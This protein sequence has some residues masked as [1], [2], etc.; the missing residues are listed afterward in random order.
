MKRTL[1]L[2]AATLLVL[3][4]A[5]VASA[6]DG[7]GVYSDVTGAINC[8]A[9]PAPYSVVTLYLVAK[10]ISSASGLSGWECALTLDPPAPL[11]LSYT[12]LNGGLNV[13]APPLFQVGLG[14]VVPYAD[15]IP[16]AN[17]GFLAPLSG[18][19][20]VG[21]GPCTPSSFG[22]FPW[23]HLKPGPGYAV[24]DEPGVLRRLVPSSNIVAGDPALLYFWVYYLGIAET[25]PGNPV[26]V[27]QSSW[28]D[29]KTLFK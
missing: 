11:G 29:V 2:L 13:L 16:L 21:I 12:L 5:P 18:G 4:L 9:A 25:C 10:N 6:V 28:G 22:R 14:V 23:E 24:G 26:G 27:E 15:A 7:I 1:S 3:S 19:V 8:N 17:V 20:K